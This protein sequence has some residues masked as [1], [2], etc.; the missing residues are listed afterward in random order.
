[1]FPEHGAS[2]ARRILAEA[3]ATSSGATL[4]TAEE[5]GHILG[6]PT[7][8]VY[9]QSR[10]GRIPTVKLGRYYRYRLEAIERWIV[11]REEAA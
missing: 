4:M 1:M 10:A 11:E 6:V 8:W 5:I 2:R 9:R 3:P 7:G